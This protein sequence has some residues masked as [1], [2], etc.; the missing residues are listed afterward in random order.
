MHAAFRQVQSNDSMGASQMFVLARFKQCS[1]PVKYS[2]GASQTVP[3]QVDSCS[4]VFQVHFV[5]YSNT[6][7]PTTHHEK[8]VDRVPLWKPSAKEMHTL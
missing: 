3:G 5:V 4:A 2:M 6:V 8:T 1:G 7:H